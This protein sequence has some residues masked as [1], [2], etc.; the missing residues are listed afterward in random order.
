MLTSRS[1][2]DHILL[3]SCSCLAHVTPII[4]SYCNAKSSP[5]P[6]VHAIAGTDHL[7]CS[8]RYVVWCGCGLPLYHAAR[9]GAV[10]GLGHGVSAKRMGIAWFLFKKGVRFSGVF[11]LGN[12]NSFDELHHAG[13]FL[14]LAIG[15]SLI[16]IG[17]LGINE[18]PN[19][20][21]N[22]LLLTN[23]CW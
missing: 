2:L 14:E 5:A 8:F 3:M 7:W 17:L 15:V 6:S 12:G 16:I 9:V 18:A 20:R 21:V 11:G 1:H 10:W 23:M 13:S 22:H 19:W 4:V